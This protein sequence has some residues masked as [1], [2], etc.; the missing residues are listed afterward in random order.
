MRSF[1]YSGYA[2]AGLLGLVALAGPARADVMSGTFSGSV[3][4]A[5]D[6]SDVLRLG[7]GIAA[8]DGIIGNFA[9]DPN[10]IVDGSASDILTISITDTTTDQTATYYDTGAGGS[11]YSVAPGSYDI[12]S[13]GPDPSDTTVSLDFD[14]G[15]IVGGVYEQAFTSAG[16]DVPAGFI[17]S[18]EDSADFSIVDAT[19]SPLPEPAGLAVI[20]VGMVGL[21]RVRRRRSG[22][23]TPD[24]ER[25]ADHLI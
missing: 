11:T 1:N 22:A 3:T 25:G 14:S 19:V 16:S 6:S 15:D 13:Y 21:V 18:G 8:G 20:S 4:S 10:Q 9:F 23:Q 5:G 7:A 2:I 17:S 12:T 24:A